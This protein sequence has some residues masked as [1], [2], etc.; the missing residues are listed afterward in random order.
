M[1]IRGN[2]QRA[3]YGDSARAARW[4]LAPEAGFAPDVAVSLAYNGPVHIWKIQPARREVVLRGRSTNRFRLTDPHSSPYA[5]K[6]GCEIDTS[7]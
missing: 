6:N 3:G 5:D 4:G 2:V 1:T 7:A